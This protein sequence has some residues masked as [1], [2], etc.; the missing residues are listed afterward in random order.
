MKNKLKITTKINLLITAWLLIILLLVNT[1]VY[2]LFMKT[3]VNMEEQI[4]RQ[5]AHDIIKEHAVS[6]TLKLPKDYLQYYISDHSYIRIIDSEHKVIDEAGND[7]NLMKDVKPKFTKKEQAKLFAM[8]EH[9]NLVVRVPINQHGKTAG[10]LEIGELL[11]GLEARKDILISVMASV[12]GIS[13]ILSFFA[14]R[15]LS[16][17]IMRPISSIISTMEE[18]EQSGVPKKI[19][20]K[21]ETKDELQ[22]MASTFNRMISKLQESIEKQRQFVSDA[23]HE[24]KTPL[25]VIISFVNLLRRHGTKDEGLTKDAIE[26]IY[27]EANRMQSLTK[28]MLELAG[29]EHP[30]TIALEPLDLALLCKSVLKQLQRVYKRS[31]QLHEE[32]SSLMIEANENQIKQVIIILLDNALKYS[33]GKIEIFLQV[34]EN[35]AALRIKDYGIGIPASELDN[36]F[37]RFYR[38]DKARSRKTGGT[39]LGLSIAK[40]IVSLHL[41]EIHIKSK[42]N[43]GTEV[44][45]LLPLASSPGSTHSQ[46]M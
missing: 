23:S 10:T 39:G 41:G 15:W 26:S 3:T 31:I 11:S 20:I 13:V 8:H 27:S 42:E 32:A 43:S 24:L 12:T 28:S 6:D 19:L 35:M 1:I 37:E 21:N 36:I 2:L 38:V 17:I 45:V 30:G 46:E 4:L 40:N 18:I 44:T 29:S 22:Q 7:R 33:S 34:Q 16:N 9:Q 25:T 5:K 14:G